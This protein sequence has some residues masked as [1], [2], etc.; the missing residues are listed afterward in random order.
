MNCTFGQIEYAHPPISAEEMNAYD[1]D[2]VPFLSM[3]GEQTR[4]H[5]THS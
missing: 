4:T 1:F 2:L 5:T 3:P